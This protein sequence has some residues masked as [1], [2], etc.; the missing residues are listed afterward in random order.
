MK[1][2]E[3]LRTRT[4]ALKVADL[5][6]MFGV[7]PQHVYRLAASGKIPSF[8][9][10]GSVRFDPGDVAAWLQEKRGPVAPVQRRGSQT[11]AA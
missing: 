10:S 6:E 3:S 1:L 7:T 5:A 9:I 4:R 8:R 11:I 2:V